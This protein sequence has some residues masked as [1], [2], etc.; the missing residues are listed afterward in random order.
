VALSGSFNT[1][2]WTSGAGDKVSLLLSWT[3]TQN[4]DANTSNITW[5]LEGA[6]S[7]STYVMA[8]GFKVVIDGE[9]VYSKSTSYRIELY[10]GTIIASGSTFIKHNDDGTRSFSVSVEGG[11]YYYEV[12]CTGSQTFTLDTIPRVSAITC[13][14]VDIG[15]NPKI[16][17][18][19][20]S[21][22]FTHTIT[23]RFG[24]LTGTIAT[25]TSATSI[26]DWMIPE[27][28]YG[29]I[30]SAKT[31]LG[32]LTCVTYK[33]DTTTGSSTCDLRVTTDE[34]KCKPTVSGTVVDTNSNTIA[35]T[36]DKEVM[37]RYCSTALCTI[38]VTLN[39]DAGSIL[40]KT[41]NN[42][43][44]SGNTLTIAGVETGVF[45]F[46]A[47]DSREYYNTDKVVKNLILY[48]RLTSNA[49]AQRVD[50]T[51]GK[52][53][54]NIEGNYFSGSFGATNNSL[55]VKYK[56]DS[57]SYV[58][59]TPNISG[60]KYTA[61]VS[62]TGMDYTKSFAF[63]VVVSDKLNSVTKKV[64]LQKG[65]PV[66]DWGENDFAF[67]IPVSI[68]STNGVYMKSKQISGTNR[69]A[70]QTKFTSFANGGTRQSLFLFGY[71]NNALVQGVVGIS[72]DGNATWNGTSGVSVTVGTAGKIELLLPNVSYDQFV[73]IS[74]EVFSV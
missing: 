50:P 9:I 62:L 23:Y 73:I 54:L 11:I 67:H 4:K 36:G 68:V 40:A 70:I 71:N 64:V 53:T 7:N 3:A 72:G 14:T 57:G 37:V 29:E 60:N 65:I 45:D 48:E 44:V 8:G 49:V 15:S 69:L 35:V 32:V 24:E 18:T 43:S 74:G 2:A 13:S 38:A 52:A 55:T 31:G 66:F 51:S 19:K 34:T 27:S 21:P 46:Y 1:S 17:I 12:N 26:T 10:N 59:V 41:I 25:K 28:F 39:K 30:P 42:A 63:E 33:G 5:K 61:T 22:D 47:K 56:I 6:R 58:T 16:V 20:A